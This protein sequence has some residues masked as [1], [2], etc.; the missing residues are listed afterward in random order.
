MG[1]NVSRGSV[2][3]YARCGGIFNIRLTTNLPR[4]L[5]VIFFKI[6]LRFDRVMVMSLCGPTFSGPTACSV[7]T[8]KTHWIIKYLMEA[9][10]G[11]NV[12]LTVIVLYSALSD[13]AFFA[14]PTRDY[15]I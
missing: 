3:T 15:A 5:P 10:F 12:V 13:P 1:I 2:A 8:V 11:R 6:R 4:N 9:L 7:H 14:F